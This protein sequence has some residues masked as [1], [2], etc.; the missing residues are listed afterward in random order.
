MA[1]TLA[2]AQVRCPLHSGSFGRQGLAADS[3]DEI[4]ADVVACREAVG[5]SAPESPIA[6]LITGHLP[7]AEHIARRYRGRGPPEDDLTQVATIG[8]INA[9]EQGSAWYRDPGLDAS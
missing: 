7:L 8:L 5:S 3:R 9:V 2:A 1:A 6:R 4:A